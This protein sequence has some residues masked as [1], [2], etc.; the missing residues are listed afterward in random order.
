MRL[1]KMLA[2][3]LADVQTGLSFILCLL[4]TVLTRPHSA[5]VQRCQNFSGWQCNEHGAS[6]APHIQRSNAWPTKQIAVTTYLR[7]CC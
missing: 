1:C 4:L 7:W 6:V 5:Y 2:H 3:R